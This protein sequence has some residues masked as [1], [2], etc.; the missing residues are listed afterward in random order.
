MKIANNL[1]EFVRVKLER[2]GGEF[3]A[4]P[5][6]SQGSNILSALSRADGLLVGPAKETLLK[7]GFQA[8]V[9]LLSP[10]AEPEAGFEEFQC[11]H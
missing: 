6:G 7:A 5:A 2:R 11:F 3:Y 10:G 4:L 8:T 1:T 9:L